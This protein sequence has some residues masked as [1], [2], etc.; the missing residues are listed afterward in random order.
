MNKKTTIAVS[1]ILLVILASSASILTYFTIEKNNIRKAPDIR[2]IADNYSEDSNLD[3]FSIDLDKSNYDYNVQHSPTSSSIGS[4]EYFSDFSKR[5]TAVEYGHTSVIGSWV[6]GTEETLL[7]IRDYSSVL[8]T[9]ETDAKWYVHHQ[10]DRIGQTLMGLS[11]FGGGG[12]NGG[13][14]DNDSFF[15]YNIDDDSYVDYNLMEVFG[16]DE[17]ELI[18]GNEY[19]IIPTQ[20]EDE[21]Y[22]DNIFDFIHINAYDVNP[23]TE[24]LFLS[25]RTLGS[26]FVV[27]YSSAPELEY[28]I[29]NPITYN[30]LESDSIGN[31]PIVR[32]GVDDYSHNPDYNPHIRSGWEDKVVS[33][34]FKDEIYSSSDPYWDIDESLGFSGQHNVKSINNFIK[35][36]DTPIEFVEGHEY[37]SIFDNHTSWRSPYDLHS[38]DGYGFSREDSN[39]E[40][41]L[42]H[43]SFS[44]FLGSDVVNPTSYWKVIDFDTENLTYE[45]I[46]NKEIPYSPIVSNAQIVNYNNVL[47]LFTYSGNHPIGNGDMQYEMNVFD[48]TN[49]ELLFDISSP[50]AD[51]G[52]RMIIESLNP[53]IKF[54][55]GINYLQQN[56]SN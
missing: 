43:G 32:N 26:I 30:F 5:Y 44:S 17:S 18:T 56:V 14:T 22:E 50:T 27:D 42:S 41:M 33:M 39:A 28:V 20:N 45:I 10:T 49:N 34:K 29:S 31:N 36:E 15:V 11:A 13:V 9:N 16:I 46:E 1:S 35:S 53:D 21:T 52:Y 12:T 37:L 4:I 8:A 51:T 7:D 48:I 3:Y 38:S 25:S 55:G 47:Y 19:K 24:R 23:E 6:D 54:A 40:G 2:L